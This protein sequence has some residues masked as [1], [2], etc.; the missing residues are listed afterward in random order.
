MIDNWVVNTYDEVFGIKEKNE[1]ERD[2]GYSQVQ[3]PRFS[4][5]NLTNIFLQDSMRK[6][7]TKQDIIIQEKQI[8]H[9]SI[10]LAKNIYKFRNT[11]GCVV[12]QQQ[13]CGDC[14]CVSLIVETPGKAVEEYY[15]LFDIGEI[16][17]KVKY[18]NDR[19]GLKFGELEHELEAFKMYLVNLSWNRENMV[20]EMN[21]YEYKH[22]DNIP[23]Y[24]LRPSMHYF[25]LENPVG[26]Y[27]G[28]YNNDYNQRNTNIQLHAYPL[29]VTNFKVY[30]QALPKEEF[31]KETLKYTTTHEA[32]IVNDLARMIEDGYGYSV[33]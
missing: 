2:S 13:Y 8:N 27:T 1:Q 16:E 15:S 10:V 4:A 20:T 28:V 24:K 21:V 23:T 33:K 6:Q 25:D 12:Y 9:N 31:M 30:N 22:P 17:L 3:S 32:C 7:V 14:G 5:T 19:F 26:S 29:I 18:V 11:N